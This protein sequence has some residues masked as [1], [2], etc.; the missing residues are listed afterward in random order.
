MVN[1]SHKYILRHP[2][3]DYY[4]IEM[5]DDFP[6]K[7]PV[8]LNEIGGEIV[9]R[10]LNGLTVVETAE[11]IAKECGVDTAMVIDDVYEVIKSIPGFT[12]EE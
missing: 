1:N 10:L 12:I 4:L 9:K 11:E 3:E 5:T 8:H 6:I 7:P 2:D